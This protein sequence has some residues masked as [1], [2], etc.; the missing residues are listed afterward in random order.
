MTSKA[1]PDPVTAAWRAHHSYLV[2]LAFRMLGDLGRAEDV[3]QEAFSRLLKARIDQID[4]QRG[5]LVVVTSRLC[6]DEIKSARAR[7]ERAEQATDIERRTPAA[8]IDPADRVTLDDN[9]RLALVVVLERLNAAE[10]VCFVLHDVFR[11]PFDTIAATVGTT[12]AHCR[13]LAR[14]ARHKVQKA[15]P[16]SP[17]GQHSGDYRRITET[18][19][20]ACANGQLDELLRIL[21]PHVSGTIDT[22]T[23]VR[24]RG[25]QQVARN[26]LRFWGQ[27]HNTLVSHD[28][29]AQPALLGFTNQHLSGI[30]L[31]NIDDDQI[32]TIH[33]V[34]DP[35]KLDFVR[36]Q[37]ALL[38]TRN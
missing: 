9:L 19:I 27:P 30:F 13:Q 4:D 10:R 31:L 28:V 21:A 6:L 11:L 16:T 20:A 5:W 33:V 32:T 15:E 18:F 2:D 35:T 23:G 17:P 22:R 29:G 38:S 14:R 12:S 25:A 3:V 24:V 8:M 26:L 7:H 36:S 34:A 37:L 1:G